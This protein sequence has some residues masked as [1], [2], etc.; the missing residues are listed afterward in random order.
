MKQETTGRPSVKS[1][2][3]NVVA[4]TLVS[5]ENLEEIR[6][7]TAVEQHP[8]ITLGDTVSVVFFHNSALRCAGTVTIWHNKNYAAIKTYTT[9]LNGEWLDALRLIVSEE[10]EQGWTMDGELVTGSLAMDI[11][12][13]QGIYSCGEFYRNREI[14]GTGR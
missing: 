9:S 11:D 8:M 1:A 2:K 5:E 10:R 3:V 13:V 4:R 14:V 12:G 7:V 6:G